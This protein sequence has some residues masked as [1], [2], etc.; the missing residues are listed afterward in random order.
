MTKAQEA[1]KALLEHLP[2]LWGDQVVEGELTLRVEANAVYEALDAIE[3]ND[4]GQRVALC[5]R[6]QS[7][8]TCT[9]SGCAHERLK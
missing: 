3:K 8:F 2:P 7:P 9:A 4:E 5:R 1:I 6:C